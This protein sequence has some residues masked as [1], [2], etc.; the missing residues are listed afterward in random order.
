MGAMR[1]AWWEGGP[2]GEGDIY[3]YIYI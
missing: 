1:G 2:R 3:R